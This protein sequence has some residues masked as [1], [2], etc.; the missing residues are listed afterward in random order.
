MSRVFIFSSWV[1]NKFDANRLAELNLILKAS[2]SIRKKG[3]SAFLKNTG[4]LILTNSVEYQIHYQNYHEDN[5][6]I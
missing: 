2:L 5:P 3:Q 1:V 4:L 6:F